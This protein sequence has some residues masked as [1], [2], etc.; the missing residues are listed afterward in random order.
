MT[1]LY[2]FAGDV[3]FDKSS[4]A[5][6]QICSV[7]LREYSET[8]NFLQYLSPLSPDKPYFFVQVSNLAE[9]SRMTIG[10]AGPDI[11][12]D[13]SPGRWNNSVG[14]HSDTGR[15]FTSHNDVANTD[16]EGFG[17]GDVFGVLVTYFGR[18]MSTVI[19]LKN[20][21]PVATRFLF[22]SDHQH[23]LPT[24]SLQNGPIEL[25]VM[26]P[27]AV[28]G[29]PQYSEKNM[30]HWIVP[31]SV[32]YN[33]IENVFAYDGG[34]DAVCVQ[35]PRPLSAEFQHFEVIIQKTSPEGKG[36]AIS[37]VTC[38]PLKPTPTCE[39][40]RDYIRWHPTGETDAVKASLG[41]RMGWGIVYNPDVR[42]CA[43][44][45]PKEQQ[46]VLCYVTINMCVSYTK[47]M[48]QPTGGFF[49]LIVLDEDAS[50]VTV[51]VESNCCP[52]VSDVMDNNFR[53]KLSEI[54]KLITSDVLAREI[55]VS[56]FNK[57]KSLVVD[58]QDQYTRVRLPAGIMGLHAIQLQRPIT[59]E[60]SCYFVEVRKL[61][62][63]SVVAVGV[64]GKNLP[65]NK[66][67]GKFDKSVGWVSRDGKLYYNERTDG[68]MAG[69]RVGEG[70]IMTV[71]VE[72]F[73]KDMSVV[74]FSKNLL[75]VGTR[76]LTQ[77]D[78]SQFLPTI[79]LCGNGNE[80][81]IDV[82]WQTHILKPRKY[83][84]MNPEHW[85]LPA[86]SVVDKS[87]NI[88]YVK[89]HEDSA[90]ALQAPY[91]LHRGYNHFEI[92]IIDEFN[93]SFPPPALAL[94]T[95]SPLD[96]A[97]VSNF[98]Q[99]FL[100][101]WAT[102]EAKDAIEVG[103]LVGWG[104]LYLQEGVHHDEEQLVICYLTV[105]RNVLLTRVIYQPPGGFY[106]LIILPPEVNRVKMEF[107]ATVINSHPFSKQAVE[108]LVTEAQQMIAEENR[109]LA[110]GGDLSNLTFDTAKLFRPLPDIP[111]GQPQE[112][113]QEPK[114]GEK[115]PLDSPRKEVTSSGV[116]KKAKA[117]KALKRKSSKKSTAKGNQ[118]TSK[119]CTIL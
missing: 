41:M 89:P 64:A 78:R 83:N 56:M 101:F 111:S 74:L 13:A 108:I 58:V 59:E 3:V 40:N 84:V 18:N 81:E 90:V 91:S 16:G 50:R 7:Q 31:A 63:D 66:Y 103:D 98:R 47:M 25:G 39:V 44:F 21:V 85:C 49:P 53:Q 118:D 15:C 29:I 96:P 71:E 104:L 88:V 14:C 117:G 106:P 68:N 116:K 19:F 5:P 12:E 60:S 22:E 27:N 34:D 75:P 54:S 114:P 93:D 110:A 52:N 1:S 76:F 55:K 37:L 45:D 112:Q 48:L 4:P 38:S 99:D 87:T 105:N 30:L 6:G 119:S 100:R 24:I 28:V 109:I 70:D 86:G 33:T 8:C 67:P 20:N 51:D 2:R 42:D 92:K 57:S 65:N 107:D 10:I 95:A 32:R 11:S 82:C 77:K 102:G 80:V 43:T 73:A 62:E 26:W 97:P 115:N 72:A 35:S 69:A 46:L 23:Y 94:S 17:I 79:V 36:P 9:H 113:Y 61:N